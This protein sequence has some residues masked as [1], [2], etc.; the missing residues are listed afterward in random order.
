MALQF[1]HAFG[2]EITAFST[3]RNKEAVARVKKN[4]VRYRAVLTN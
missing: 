4:K 2:C 1:A 3:S